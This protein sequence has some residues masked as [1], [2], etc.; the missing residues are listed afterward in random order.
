LLIAHSVFLTRCCAEHAL[1]PEPAAEAE[2]AADTMDTG[3]CPKLMVYG[4]C[5]D[6]GSDGS[7]EVSVADGGPSQCVFIEAELLRWSGP[8][9][10]AASPQP[11]PLFMCELP[12]QGTDREA[13]QRRARRIAGHADAVLFG[14]ANWDR[15]RFPPSY[16][17]MLVRDAGLGAWP[18]INARDRNR[19]AL[20]GELLAL[21]DLGVPGVH[22]VTG[23]HSVS[24]HRRDA[25]PVFDLDSTR[26]TALAA[27]QG[28]QV[29]VAASPHTPPV[30][31]RPIRTAD[32]ARAG[33]TVAMIDQPTSID[34]VQTF[35][36]AVRAITAPMGISMQ[37]VPVVTIVSSLDDLSRWRQYPNARIPEGWID[38]LAAASPATVLEIGRRLAIELA[39]SLNEID[40]VNGVL[41][42]STADP[43]A[44]DNMSAVFADALDELRDRIRESLRVRSAD[45]GTTQPG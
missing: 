42:G 7:C 25:A 36:D 21:A 9:S 15:V 3:L 17:A 18:G 41:L 1:Q 30:A 11:G 10:S 33:A 45:A 19:V 35:V 40:G 23:N 27:E 26:L 43:A 31:L 4:P 8:T 38:P 28:L 24:G 37:F 32:K 12:E 44:G 34:E 5:A 2:A 22:C 39:I 16:R 6:V 20:E 14:D 13:L 29:S